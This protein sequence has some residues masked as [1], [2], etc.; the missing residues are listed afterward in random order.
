[1]ESRALSGS[2]KGRIREL[3]ERPGVYLFKDR[4]G[5]PVYIGKAVSIKKRVMSHFRSFGE[6]FSKEGRMLS[7]LRSIGFI[8]TPTEAEALLLEASL[9]KENLPKYNQELRDDKSYPFIKIT[10]EPFPRLLIVRGRKADGGKYFGPYTSGYLLQQAVRML[11]RLFPMRTCKRLP[12]K[13]CLMYHIGQCHGPCVYGVAQSEYAGIV[14]ELEG[15]LEGR[16]DMLV[17]HLARQMKNYSKEHEY[18]K[19]RTV[20]QEIRALSSVPKTALPKKRSESVLDDLKSA[21]EL[22]QKPVRM[23]CFDIS[24][25][26]GKEAVASMV[27][28]RDAKPA[29]ADYR[30]FRIKT[31]EGIDDYRMMQEVVTRRYRRLKEEGRSLPDLVVIDGGKGHLNAAL[32]AL[33][34]LDLADLP[35]ISI[36]KQHEHLFTPLRERPYILPLD[37]PVLELIRHLRDEAHR[38]AISYHRRLHRKVAALSVL[39]GIPG[40]GEKTRTKLLRRFGSVTRLRRTSEEALAEE[41]GIGPKT[42]RLIL[43]HLGQKKEVAV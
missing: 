21:L 25:I 22:P 37:S 24:N 9:V 3:P 42:A 30:R 20:Y 14:K 28:F 36:A 27:V 43:A 31:V 4:A 29:R 18:E 10:A 8:E 17:K 11:R 34:A 41:D 5:T 32:K 39:D 33:R 19:A 7:E 38:F 23:E 26:Q 35:L 6:T 2:L 1:M 13:V 16:R 15:F 40:V 12:K